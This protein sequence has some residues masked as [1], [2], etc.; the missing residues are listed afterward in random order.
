MTTDVERI[1]Q[2]IGAALYRYVQVA[3]AETSPQRIPAPESPALTDE[4]VEPGLRST[5]FPEPVRNV[6]M[7]AAL[8]HVNAGDHL[9][10][11]GSLLARIDDGT[12]YAHW[13]LT[14][15][16]LEN[17][18]YSVWLHDTAISTEQRV[19]RG[20]RRSHEDHARRIR[21]ASKAGTAGDEIVATSRQRQS[22][23][24]RYALDRRWTLDA[25][26]LPTLGRDLPLIM[27]A[28]DPT[29]AG[30]L[31]WA[32]SSGIGHGDLWALSHHIV[33]VDREPLTG[34]ARAGIVYSASDMIQAV[35]FASHAFNT[36]VD[37]RLAFLGG[38][39]SEKLHDAYLCYVRLL[40]PHWRALVER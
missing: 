10:A 18:L 1:V 14:R 30:A 31:L 27:K 13:S 6:H 2:P 5:E 32:L 22:E 40:H 7:H 35:G 16:V 36:S 12:I 38:R 24:A 8:S 33:E 37:T 39:R 21:M 19:L 29:E 23:I 15:P 17:S 26:K 34:R 25:V 20:L 4:L 28:P 11:L 9:R 3:D